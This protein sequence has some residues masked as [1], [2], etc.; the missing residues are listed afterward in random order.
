M[1]NAIV[2]IMGLSKES[3]GKAMLATWHALRNTR[4]YTGSSLQPTSSV[5]LSLY[6]VQRVLRPQTY[7][8]PVAMDAVHEQAPS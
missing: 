1:V 2:E 3:L 4:D 8:K 7:Y 5:V 6:C